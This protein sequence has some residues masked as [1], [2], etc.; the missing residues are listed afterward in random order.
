[1]EIRILLKFCLLEINLR[2]SKLPYPLLCSPLF[3]VTLPK[4]P[5]V[6]TNISVFFCGI[7]KIGL[8]HKRPISKDVNFFHDPVLCV[9]LDVHRPLSTPRVSQLF[10]QRVLYIVTGN[11]DDATV[12]ESE[13]RGWSV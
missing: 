9:A 12:T 8:P 3:S 1:M 10:I 13:Y 6:S 4:S 7:F 2:R 5:L 11:E